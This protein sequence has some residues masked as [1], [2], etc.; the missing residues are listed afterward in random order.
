MDPAS[1]IARLLPLCT[2]V[3]LLAAAATCAP[4]TT[5]TA[6]DGRFLPNQWTLRPAGTSHPLGD[7]PVS[8]AVS[9]DGRHAAIPHSGYGAHEVRVFDL[10]ERRE[11]ARA[12]VRNAWFGAAFS[13]DGRTLYLSAGGDDALL[14]FPFRDGTLGNPTTTPLHAGFPRGTR[15]RP[16][17]WYP[18]GVAVS[19]DG[20]TVY[21]AAQNR[22]ALLAVEGAPSSRRVRV[23][24]EFGGENA[25]PYKVVLHPGQ[26]RA[27]VSLWG[28]SAVAE[29]DLASSGV[30]R[31]VA[32]DSHPND[33][34]LSPDGKRLFVACAN[35]N[36]VDVIDTA[37]HA[38]EERLNTAL[39]PGMPPG[40]TP[41]GLA[42]SRDGS[43]LLVANADTNMV[44]VFDVSRRA[45]AR[46]RG[47]IPTE[48]YPTGVAF[49]PQGDI[50]TVCGKGRGSLANP[51][52]PD[53]T[54]ST[55]SRQ[56]I[57]GLMRGSIVFV[58][59]PDDEAMKRHTAE[60]YKT[61]PLRADL[62]P[63]AAEP[64]NPVPARVG[65]PSPIKHCVYIIKEN[66]TYDQVLGDMPEGNGDASLCLFGEK[67][68]P[69]HHALARE[70]V[71][72]DNFFVEAEVSAD[73][74]EWTTGAY[75]T[76]YVEKTWPVVYGKHAELGYPAEGRHPMGR[77]ESGHIWDRAK[78]AGV[79]YRSYG[80]FVDDGSSACLGRATD[81]ALE[82]NFDPCFPSY[83]LD[84]TDVE[85]AERFIHE[86]RQFETS[87]TLPGLVI[88][89]LPNDHTHG[90]ALGKP[91]PR[92]YVADN[93]L[94]LGMVI[95][96][97][98]HSRF[99]KEMAVFVVEDDAQN[100]P[101]HVDAH[102][103]VAFVAGPH[104]RR[105]AVV[106]QMYS[107]SSMLR[108]IEL[109]LG[110]QPMS[111]F[112]AAAR[113]MIECFT[114]TPDFTPYECRPATWPLDERNQP[115]AP[116]QRESAQL[117]ATKEDSNPDVL[118]NEIIWKSVHGADSVMPAPVRAAFVHPRGGS[119]DDD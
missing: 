7:F 68:T 11:V 72:L 32:T 85:R 24:A 106:H 76:D 48:W 12:G 47:F 103:T 112:D 119:D 19:A 40:S 98:S 86:L 30:V 44:S 77:G 62:A 51:D 84:I 114:A 49:G 36:L 108:T 28:A 97:L 64:G 118:F 20:R 101:D 65:E 16:K 99:W 25:M 59:A 14:A 23:V 92:A 50:V 90:T 94:A 4:D 35:T 33:M 2:V 37:K 83:N 81:P 71:L 22:N 15:P 111:Q 67:V 29:V 66:R 69:N 9:P 6:A 115:G 45:M 70:F 80:E 104:V 41:N 74:H 26:P 75:A 87:G 56:Y 43:T 95:E 21:V 109:I 117:D 5:S 63:V 110:L 1:G 39:F 113:P 8:V 78:E 107:T 61:S 17:P 58:P 13:P 27:W 52:G 55:A 3:L 96:A 93:D 91:T 34:V 38:V 46:S 42:I 102:R 18:C 73:G 54:T 79:S 88:I 31:R 53:P 105:N 82:G 116:M 10:A 57:G 100:G 60:A 89:R